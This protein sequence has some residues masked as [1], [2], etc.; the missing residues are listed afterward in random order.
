MSRA[1]LSVFIIYILVYKKSFF[2]LLKIFPILKP[3]FILIKL[4]CCDY[5]LKWNAQKFASKHQKKNN[6]LTPIPQKY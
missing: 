4:E 6:P 2:Y 3:I 1:R 5:F